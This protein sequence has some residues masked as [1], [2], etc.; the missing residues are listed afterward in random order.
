MLISRRKGWESLKYDVSYS[1]K[2]KREQKIWFSDR[3]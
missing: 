2:E 3:S 1:F